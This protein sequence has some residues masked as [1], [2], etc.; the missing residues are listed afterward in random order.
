[1]D[2]SLSLQNQD[3]VV[4]PSYKGV[5]PPENAV[6][7]DFSSP[8]LAIESLSFAESRGVPLVLCTTGLT[9]KTY[10]KAN[11]ASKRIPLFL[12][13]N[14]S[15]GIT[16]IKRA[17][18]E[19]AKMLDDGFDIEIIE[20]HHRKKADSQRNSGHKAELQ[21]QLPR[22][23]RRRKMQKGNRHTFRQRRN[24]NGKAR[25]YVHRRR[26]SYHLLSL[27]RHKTRFR[28]RSAQ[29]RGV[30]LKNAAGAL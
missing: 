11:L 1:M 20:Y 16:Y 12:D 8:G 29:G 17:V 2:K 13:S 3:F 24:D 27:R 7:I 9:A 10:E 15:P 5:V 14:V 30:R 26:R 18:A 25:G 28:A 6:I 19:C 23:G 22:H 21:N 4:Y